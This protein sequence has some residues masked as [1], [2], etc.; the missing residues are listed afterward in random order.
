MPSKRPELIVKL[1][2]AL[3]KN[4]PALREGLSA[5]AKRPEL[6]KLDAL[7]NGPLP[8]L[9]RALYEWHDGGDAFYGN[10]VFLS[11]ADVLESMAEMNE[12]ARPAR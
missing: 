12:K 7:T 5:G 1:D 8:A 3:R 10:Y 2:A 9:F 6:A 11:I 4:Y